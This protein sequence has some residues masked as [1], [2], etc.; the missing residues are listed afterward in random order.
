MKD[1]MKTPLAKVR[2]YG[3]ARSGTH[4][5][6]LERISGVALVPLTVG[7]VLTLIY[8]SQA[9]QATIVATLGSPLV[10]V[11][12]ALFIGVGIIHM[13]IGMRVIIEDY[14]HEEPL[15]IAALMANTFFSYTLGAICLYALFKLNFG[16]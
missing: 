5:F 16:L 10:A 6:W 13:K 4:E 9:S 1:S 2:G 11:M 14:I 8:L 12:M 7:F 3:S 15:K